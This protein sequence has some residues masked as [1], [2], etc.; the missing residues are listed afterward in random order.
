MHELSLM[1]RLGERVLAVAS[2]Q[3]AERVLSIHLRIGSLAGVDP[4]ALR[5]AAEVVLA[6]TCAEGA[7]L[8]IDA[9]QAA[10]WCGPCGV[11]FAAI[12]GC[13]DCPRCGALSTRL[14]RGKELSL[15]SI[16]L[17]P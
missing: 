2:E 11:D 3:G 12:A 15:V 17:V 4:E 7:S 1:E 13:C 8:V 6:G 5:F 10:C 14:L 16:E 9:I